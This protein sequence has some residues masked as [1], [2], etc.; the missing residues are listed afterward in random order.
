M[1]IGKWGWEGHRTGDKFEMKLRRS[2]GKRG[3]INNIKIMKKGEKEE[4]D[5]VHKKDN[6]LFRI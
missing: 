4:R 3:K 5:S 2:C 1:K 6:I